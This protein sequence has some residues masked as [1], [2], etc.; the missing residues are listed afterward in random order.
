MN[1]EIIQAFRAR[2]KALG[3]TQRETARRSGSKQYLVSR[4]ESGQDL[5]LSTLLKL[6]LAL[7]LELLPVPREDAAKVQSLLQAKREPPSSPKPPSLLERYHVKD[8]EGASNG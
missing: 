8:D 1:S 7:D 2:R 6:A 4:F 5:R 3:L